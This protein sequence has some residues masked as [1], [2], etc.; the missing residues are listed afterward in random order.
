MEPLY[1][2]VALGAFVVIEIITMGLTTI[3]FAGG[4]LVAFVAGICGAPVWLQVVLFLLVSVLL[5]IFTRP[6]AEK[7]FNNS[8]AKTNVD[9]LIGKHCR[10]IEEI[11]NFSQTG[12]I[13]LNGIEWTARSTG[14]GKIPLDAKVEVKEIK[15]AHAVVELVKL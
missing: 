9:N 2:L 10:V 8:R 6:I 15:G 4:S 1:W 13:M 7:H 3:W 12:K 14:E 11:D 5:L